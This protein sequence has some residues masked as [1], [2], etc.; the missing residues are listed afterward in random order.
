MLRE[1]EEIADAIGGVAP[2]GR[3]REKG[4]ALA[5]GVYIKLYLLV[6]IFLTVLERASWKMELLSSLTV[7]CASFI[8]RAPRSTNSLKYKCMQVDDMR[9][10]ILQY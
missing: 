7:R 8:S 9:R 4:S 6:Y 2:Y 1:S 5:Q 10:N 3:T